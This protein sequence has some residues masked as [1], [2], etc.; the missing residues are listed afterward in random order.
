MRLTVLDKLSIG[1]ALL[2]AGRSLY[3]A[4]HSNFRL[5]GTAIR[6]ELPVLSIV[7]PARNEERQIEGCVRSLSGQ[8]YPDF[9]V[10]VVDDQSTDAT[11]SILARLATEDRR[12]HV[13]A[14]APLPDGWVGKPWALMQGARASRGALLLFT[15]ADTV[16]DASASA[17]AASYL[18]AF[19]LDVLSLLTDQEFGTRA[20]RVVLPSILW[21]IGFAVGSLEALN[22]VNRPSHALFNGQ[23]IM[24]RRDKYFEL[25]GHEAVRGEIAEDY[26]LAHLVKE[27]RYRSYLAGADGLV[28]TRMYRSFHEIWR[29]FGKN[30]AL[31]ARENVPALIAGATFLSLVAP[32]SQL[33]AVRALAQRR[34]GT[35]AAHALANMAAIA[36]TEVGMRRSRFPKYSALWLPLGLT[37]MLGI[38][39]KSVLAHG[40]GCVEWRGRR[41]GV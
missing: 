25:G 39:G 3:I 4:M 41:Y 26:E 35:A 34:Y 22:D 28:R 11:S 27:R 33:L 12:L 40:R 5:D 19:G 36:A 30:L 9:E 32:V 29:G 24:F 10:I 38:L 8:R 31:G 23:Y 15:D 18:E 14:G 6:Q 13:I 20:E 21:T 17:A 37:V 2:Y 1:A 7:V 16:H